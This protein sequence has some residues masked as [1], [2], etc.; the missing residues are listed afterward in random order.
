MKSISGDKY[1]DDRL[2][3]FLCY[4]CNSDRRFSHWRLVIQC[5]FACYYKICFLYV[6]KKIG[7]FYYYLISAFK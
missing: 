3:V 5:S 2:S 7:F 1:G 4:F 6:F